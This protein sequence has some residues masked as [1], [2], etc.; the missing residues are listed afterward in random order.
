MASN[1]TI[2]LSMDHYQALRRIAQRV[3]KAKQ[4]K[5]Q[6]KAAK[7]YWARAYWAR[8]LR[9]STFKVGGLRFIK[10]GSLSISICVTNPRREAQ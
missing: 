7:D 10:L 5:L 3:A 2:T 6:A 9:F 1:S 4:R 8:A